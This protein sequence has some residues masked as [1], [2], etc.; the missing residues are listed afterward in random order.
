[1][2]AI[3]VMG[4]V[5]YHLWPA[6]FTGGFLGVDIFFVVSG[7]L[8][9][10]HIAKGL[11]A[12]GWQK[13]KR[14]TFLRDF[15]F[16]RIRRLA[17]AALVTLAGV[18]LI[19]W[20]MFREKAYLLS[21]TAEQVI[22]STLFVQN[23]Q[24]A[25]DAV[26]YLAQGK[27]ITP[28]EHFWSLSVEEQFY[29]VWPMLLMLA[30]IVGTRIKEPRMSLWTVVLGITAVSLGYGIYLT[31]IDPAAAYFV[32]PARL[33]ELSLGGVIAL[34]PTFGSLLNGQTKLSSGSR[35]V[36]SLISGAGLTICFAS[37]FLL[38]GT[39]M[40][41]P[42]YWALV[43]TIGVG[44][45]IWV[46]REQHISSQ[47]IFDRLSSFRPVQFLGDISYSFYLW[48]FVCIKT[49]YFRE[50]YFGDAVVTSVEK[51][52]IVVPLSLIL[53]TLSYHLVERTFLKVRRKL[54]LLIFTAVF[55]AIVVVLAAAEHRYG[56]ENGAMKLAETSRNIAAA[57]DADL[58]NGIFTKDLCL[59]AIAIDW[60]ETC[61]DSYGV[62]DDKLID[63]V[64]RDFDLASTKNCDA[65]EYVE[66]LCYFGD[67]SSNKTIL[68]WGDSHAMHFS[69][70][71][72][73]AAK[74]LGY[75]LV[76]AVRAGCPPLE[77]S[78]DDLKVV[79]ARDPAWGRRHADGCIARN[80]FILSSGE[81]RNADIV[82]LASVYF[83]ADDQNS[84]QLFAQ[85]LARLGEKKVAVIQDAPQIR[86][87]ADDVP[88]DLA[89][90]QW[91][92]LKRDELNVER[93][94]VNLNEPFFDK[95]DQAGAKY[96]RISTYDAFCRDNKCYLAIGS[97]PVY[98]DDG[99][100]TGTYSRTLG[101][102]FAKKIFKAIKE[103]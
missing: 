42:G 90:K 93:S 81:F 28:V 57:I 44:L 55:M 47:T 88:V 84:L 89:N 74:H 62:I 72:D 65:A 20:I 14:L 59:G 12:G 67:T 98:R 52:L 41:F 68:L 48:H 92:M 1:M 85:N 13:G 17:P 31:N 97:L 61:G 94:S 87:Y 60:P 11:E 96:F 79:H 21:I 100:I 34:L 54:T 32:T 71:I 50:L 40:S 36:Y 30:F 80:N 51:L 91:Y 70:G 75:K 73:L 99:H 83:A 7:F 26:D 82:L 43:P 76:L 4:V 27:D 16:K 77:F 69:D 19:L 5:L 53:A 45:L 3:A 8:M 37:L 63:D 102:W 101:P 18:V 25:G 49:F 46:G 23:W 22:A 64:V 29:F 35:A 10:S 38:D 95:L 86:K 39:K 103:Q 2:R 6:H 78:A 56:I 24:L 66:R 33:W 9:T 15:Y 58:E